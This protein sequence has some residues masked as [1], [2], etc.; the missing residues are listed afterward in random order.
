MVAFVTRGS[1]VRDGDLAEFAY[2][3]MKG[4]WEGDPPM[5]VARDF[6]IQ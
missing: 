4:V 3:N 1:E 2:R 6:D 5:G